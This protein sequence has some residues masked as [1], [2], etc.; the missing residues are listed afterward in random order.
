MPD[1]LNLLSLIV[2]L[3]AYLAA[4]RFYA[5]QRLATK[6]T[7][8]Q[9]LKAFLFLLVFADAPLVVAGV[10]LS[11]QLFWEPFCTLSASS[12][13]WWVALLFLIAVMVMSVYHLAAWYKSVKEY[14]KPKVAQ[15]GSAV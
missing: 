6:P 7:N 14:F 4:L 5:I 1:K 13:S 2:A 9:S 10:L 11:L 12:S 3:S 15:P 8:A